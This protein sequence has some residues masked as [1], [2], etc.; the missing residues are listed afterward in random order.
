MK[1]GQKPKRPKK[2]ER[3]HINILF[4]I[5]DKISKY[6]YLPLVVYTLLNL[7]MLDTNQH[8]VQ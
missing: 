8:S 1:E 7:E 3:R 4:T 2:H 5:R 6:M